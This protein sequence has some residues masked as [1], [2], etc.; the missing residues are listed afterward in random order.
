MTEQP[1]NCIKFCSPPTEEVLRL[2]KEGFHYRGQFIADAGEAHRLMV[3]FL[4]QNTATSR[5]DVKPRDLIRRFIDAL[6]ML[7]QWECWYEKDELD[8]L[9]EARAYLDQPEPQMPTDEE[10]LELMPKTMRDEF[11]Y[12]AKVCSD[13]TGGQV[14]P[15]IFRVCLNHSALEYARA[16]LARW[17]CQ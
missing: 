6:E 16:I 3:E 13:A 7:M 10:L 17:G 12:S 15:G 5:C 8:L 2:D 11:S 14:K 4:K 9:A 1:A